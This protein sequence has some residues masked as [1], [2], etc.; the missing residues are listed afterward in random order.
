[1]SWLPIG[2]F[3]HPRGAQ[4]GKTR[5]NP[6]VKFVEIWNRLAENGG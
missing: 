3:T 2:D 4:E 6:L 1:V 5:E